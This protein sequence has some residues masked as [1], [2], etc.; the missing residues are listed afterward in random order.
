MDGHESVGTSEDHFIMCYTHQK[1]S[2]LEEAPEQHSK[3]NDLACWSWQQPPWCWYNEHTNPVAMV[4]KMKVI[5][6]M[7]QDA[8]IHGNTH[9]PRP[10]HL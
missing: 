7:S 8:Q 3:Q 2:T 6:G 5:N 10:V 1:A 4:A 9:L